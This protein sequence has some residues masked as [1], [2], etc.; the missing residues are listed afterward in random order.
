MENLAINSEYIKLDQL[1]KYAGITGCGSQAKTLILQQ[2][3]K[4]N[5]Q[6]CTQRGRKIRVGDVVEITY[7]P[8]S[9]KLT[10]VGQ[11]A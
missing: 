4:V 5:G 7:Q 8:L 2:Y 1:I 6:I 3:V 10:I 9:R 11:G